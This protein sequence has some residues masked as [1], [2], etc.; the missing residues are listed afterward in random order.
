MVFV[1]AVEAMISSLS[2]DI[3]SWGPIKILWSTYRRKMARFS[4]VQQDFNV[5]YKRGTYI[6]KS[7]NLLPLKVGANG[8]ARNSPTTS[9]QKKNRKIKIKLKF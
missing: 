7:H 5:F 6:I 3:A 1:E 8:N 2:F 9:G 4:M